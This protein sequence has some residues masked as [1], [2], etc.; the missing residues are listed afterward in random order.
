MQL[1]TSAL[2]PEKKIALTS[3]S[4]GSRRYPRINV[5]KQWSDYFCDDHHATKSESQLENHDAT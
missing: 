5:Q 4:I 1:K 3:G 2:P